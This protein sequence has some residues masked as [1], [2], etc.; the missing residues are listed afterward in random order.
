MKGAGPEHE[1]VLG[2][3]ESWMASSSSRTALWQP[4][5]NLQYKECA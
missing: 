2:Q 4:A 3:E 5:M 1:W